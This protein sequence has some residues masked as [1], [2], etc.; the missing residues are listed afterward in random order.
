MHRDGMQKPRLVSG[1]SE[2]GWTIPVNHIP[3]TRQEQGKVIIEITCL[4]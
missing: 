3:T 2:R 4:T 1:A